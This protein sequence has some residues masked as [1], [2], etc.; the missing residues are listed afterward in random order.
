MKFL[1]K[2][3]V[4]AHKFIVTAALNNIIKKI[5]IGI[6]MSK[7]FD[8]VMRTKLI[9]IIRNKGIG[10]GD[11]EIIKLLLSNT[12]LQIKRGKEIS[13]KFETDMGVPQGDGS[14]LFTLYL[15]E[16]LVEID[17]T[18]CNAWP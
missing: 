7:A 18:I 13:E 17:N 11:I 5:F 10:E 1:N 2:L 9:D 8:T 12:C 4:L 6:D 3:L 14:K 15:N 16:A